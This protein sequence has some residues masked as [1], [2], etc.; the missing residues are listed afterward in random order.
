MKRKIIKIDEEKCTGC[1]LCVPGCAEGAIQIIDG[2]ARLV[3]DVY[4]DGLGAC[5]GECPEGALSIEERDAEAFDEKQV[6]EHLAKTFVRPIAHGSP[7]MPQQGCPGSAH[8]ALE[9]KGAAVLS[10]APGAVQSSELTHWPVQLPLVNPAA[11]FFRG[12][13][14]VLAADCVAYAL[15]D[16]HQRF[17]KGKSLAIACPKLD[18]GQEEYIEKIRRLADEAKINTLTVIIM[19]VPCCRGLMQVAQTGLQKAKRKVPLK[20]VIVGIRG[21]ILSEDWVN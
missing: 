4:C 7:V 2:K 9:R 14:V 13:D 19:Q 17:L 3:S 15:G 5:L 6:Q 18:D 20:A 12:Q 21:E 11:D 8:V 1:G 10:A 16:F